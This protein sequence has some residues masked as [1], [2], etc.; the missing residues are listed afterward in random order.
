MQPIPPSYYEQARDVVRSSRVLGYNLED[1]RRATEIMELALENE[2]PAE[3]I[4]GTSDGCPRVTV[5]PV[6][7]ATAPWLAIAHSDYDT[8][9]V[10]FAER[11]DA[12]RW[13]E[14]MARHLVEYLHDDEEDWPGW[15]AHIA[16]VARREGSAT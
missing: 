5:S 9:E 3:L 7:W 6:L 10:L 1:A 12:V 16:E 15:E 13:A 8:E 11:Q 4:A 2:G 14:A